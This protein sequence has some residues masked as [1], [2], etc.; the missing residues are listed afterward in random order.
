MR[1]ARRA[2]AHALGE[3]RSD[4]Q[5]WV[6]FASPREANRLLWEPTKAQRRVRRYRH[7]G[8]EAEDAWGDVLVIFI[9]R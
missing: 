7:R 2:I 5:A 6:R 1:L 3:G 8:G 4:L 9:R